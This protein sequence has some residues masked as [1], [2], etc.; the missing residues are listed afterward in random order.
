MT[1]EDKC[2]ISFSISTSS[3]KLQSPSTSK[4]SLWYVLQNV[5]QKLF[6]GKDLLQAYQTHKFMDTEKEPCI[7]LRWKCIVLRWLIDCG[8]SV[9]LSVHVIQDVSFGYPIDRGWITNRICFHQMTS[10][11]I[12]AF[13]LKLFCL[14]GE[15][16]L[17]I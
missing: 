15:S 11:A 16:W 8:T 1:I 14:V 10:Q 3:I 9:S 4:G 6:L 17:I 2:Y 13:R 12:L 5:F 7:V